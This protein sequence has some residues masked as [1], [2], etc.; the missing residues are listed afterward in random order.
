MKHTCPLVYCVKLCSVRL[1]REGNRVPF[2]FPR[3]PLFQGA[4][5]SL[6]C[7]L[8]LP[9]KEQKLTERKRVQFG[10]VDGVIH[11]ASFG[12]SIRRRR[13]FRLD[14]FFHRVSAKERHV[15]DIFTAVG[16]RHFTAVFFQ[17]QEGYDFVVRTFGVQLNLGVLV[18]NAKRFNGSLPNVAG[19]SV[20]RDVFAKAFRPKLT[21][22]VCKKL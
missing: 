7:L 15:G 16:D 20:Q 3:S 10:K 18:G 14:Q 17:G 4:R 9:E 8:Q 1:F 6:F 13:I 21:V 5:R 22:P 12:Q 2:S 19:L 11:S